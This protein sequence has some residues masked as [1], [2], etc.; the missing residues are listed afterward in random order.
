[1]DVQQ[2]SLNAVY[3]VHWLKAKNQKTRWIEELQSHQEAKEER[4]IEFSLFMI[5]LFCFC[6]MLILDVQ[7]PTYI[8]MDALDEC[9]NLS[10][11]PSPREEVLEFVDEL[12]GLHLSNLHL[13]VTSRPE[14]R[15]QLRGSEPQLPDPR[16]A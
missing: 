1:M 12:V 4:D 7:R 2:I 3:Q 11:I 13:C 5:A 10:T 6:W 16:S 8:I 15:R 14:S 9:P